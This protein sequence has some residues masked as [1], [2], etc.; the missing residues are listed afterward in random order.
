[1]YDMTKKDRIYKR[2]YESG[3]H[4]QKDKKSKT[5]WAC[6]E[7]GG[8]SCSQKYHFNVA[9]GQKK[10]WEDVKRRGWIM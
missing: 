4:C 10:Q 6:D 9:Y 2:K 5:L 7:K 8:E 3:S 1:M